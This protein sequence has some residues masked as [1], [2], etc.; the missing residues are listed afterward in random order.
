MISIGRWSLKEQTCTC[1]SFIGS[2]VSVHPRHCRVQSLFLRDVR[3]RSSNE[4]YAL[5]RLY[6]CLPRSHSTLKL[7]SNR[8]TDLTPWNDCA[9]CRNTG[10][11]WKPHVGPVLLHGRFDSGWIMSSSATSSATPRYVVSLPEQ[12]S[13]AQ[14]SPVP[15]Y[16]GLCKEHGTPSL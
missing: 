10:I 7:S 15:P 14:R 6:L 8:G 4:G 3:R 5:I 9:G 11:N 12:Q 2:P 1:A 13:E 16:I